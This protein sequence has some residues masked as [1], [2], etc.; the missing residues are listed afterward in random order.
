MAGQKVFEISGPVDRLNIVYVIFGW[1]GIGTLLPWNFFITVN[2]YWDYKYRSVNDTYD[3]YLSNDASTGLND[4]QTTWKSKMS[5][6]SMVPNVTMLLLN[7][8]FGHHFKTTPRLLISLILVIVLF[9][10]TSAMAVIDTDDWQAT[11]MLITIISVVFIN[12]NSAIFQGTVNSIYSE[13][14]NL[15][16]PTRSFI[17]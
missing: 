1:L 3:A 13:L 10:F 17:F 5:V 2:S 6:A 9:G 16:R 15:Y 11:F 8:A 14:A 7:A 4:I 12:V